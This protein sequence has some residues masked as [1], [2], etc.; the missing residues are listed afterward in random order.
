MFG[1]VTERAERN[2]ILFGI[3]AQLAARAEVVNLQVLRS[4]AKLLPTNHS[5]PNPPAECDATV[6]SAAAADEAMLDLASLRVALT[7]YQRRSSTRIRTA[8]LAAYVLVALGWIV[9]IGNLVWIAVT[10]AEALTRT[11]SSRVRASGGR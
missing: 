6:P 8:P 10:S 1:A 11:N 5:N 2:E 9:P 4:A 7:R 3:V